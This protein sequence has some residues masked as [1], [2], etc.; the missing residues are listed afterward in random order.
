[1]SL[2]GCEAMDRRNMTLY[3]HGDDEVYQMAY[4]MMI[5]WIVVPI[6]FLVFQFIHIFLFEAR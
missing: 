1:V 4:V 6:V 3:D 2:P 5:F